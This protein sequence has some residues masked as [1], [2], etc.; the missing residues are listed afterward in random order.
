MERLLT[1]LKSIEPNK[2]FKER[3]RALILNSP[4][5][6][7]S[8]GIFNRLLNS[9]QFSAAFS[10]AA[11]FIFLIIGGLSML[12]QRILSPA[13]LSSL[14]PENLTEEAASLDFQIQLSQAEYYE[15]SAEK[16][17]IALNETSGEL[18]N[19]ENREEE[20]NKLLNEITL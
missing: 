20:L 5:S 10:L 17:E 18:K 13:L 4:Q 14:D 3:S 8:I 1:K 12:S 19:L 15:E 7:I 6:G 9:A 16:V 2:E 11:I